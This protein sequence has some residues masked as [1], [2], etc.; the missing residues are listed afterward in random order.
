MDNRIL[1]AYCHYHGSWPYDELPSGVMF[2]QGLRVTVEDFISLGNTQS[3]GPLVHSG[4][5]HL[6]RD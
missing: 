1:Q 2:Y 4:N 5:E 3:R 6:F